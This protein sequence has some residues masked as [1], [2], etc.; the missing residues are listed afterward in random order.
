MNQKQATTESKTDI[1]LIVAEC[2]ETER[3][4][5]K[6]ICLDYKEH[7]FKEFN[8]QVTTYMLPKPAE[9]IKETVD[10]IESS[11][12]SNSEGTN[13]Q[14]VVVS[15]DT[16]EFLGCGGLHH[17]DTKTP[18]LGVWIKVSAHGHGYGKEVMHAI[19]KWADEHLNYEYLL[20]PVD[21][22]NIPSRKIPESMNGKI[23]KEY[24]ETNL[25]GAVLHILEYRIYP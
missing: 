16:G 23:E 18:E 11:M 15:K 14:T 22:E 13:F 12:K 25:S 6:S 17:I 20:Y 8:S 10:F 21:K 4:L 24:Q 5:L 9:T 3:L 7:I 1:G 19:K 2:N